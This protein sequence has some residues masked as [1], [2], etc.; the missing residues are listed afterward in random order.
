MATAWYLKSFDDEFGPISFAEL[1]ELVRS[2]TVVEDDLLRPAQG[3]QFQR[4]HSVI[5]LFYM[6]RRPPAN[7]VSAAASTEPSAI[8]QSASADTTTVASPPS[9]DSKP[10]WL[11]RLLEARDS[12]LS[13]SGQAAG[14]G[15]RT[16]DPAP[17]EPLTSD[18]EPQE[19]TVDDLVAETYTEFECGNDSTSRENYQSLDSMVNSSGGAWTRAVDD[20]LAATDHRQSK[21]SI[22]SRRRGLTSLLSHATQ[23]CS[24]VVERFGG[25]TRLMGLIYRVLAGIICANLTAYWIMSWSSHEALRFPSRTSVTVHAFPLIGPCTDHEYLFWLFDAALGAGFLAYWAATVLVAK[26]EN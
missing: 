2:G 15:Q 24:Q 25:G 10:E 16:S 21:R 18:L 17:D 8:D 4:A 22:R 13:G 19:V 14:S 11:L 7:S 23:F 6:A 9:D 12:Q 3:D 26:T 5:G 20:A 1:V